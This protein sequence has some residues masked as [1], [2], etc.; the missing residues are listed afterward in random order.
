MGW[1]SISGLGEGW[2][3]GTRR[4]IESSSLDGL[5]RVW[6]SGREAARGTCKIGV[7]I[8]VVV[9]VHLLVVHAA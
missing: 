8:H 9:L 2:D 7:H 3:A 6:K 1:N 4:L 5:A